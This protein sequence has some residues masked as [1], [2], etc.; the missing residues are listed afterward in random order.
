MFK[1]REETSGLA[2]SGILDVYESS[3]YLAQEASREQGG[4]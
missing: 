3:L 4:A 1:W 2:L